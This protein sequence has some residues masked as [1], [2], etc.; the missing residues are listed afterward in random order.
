[1]PRI[2]ACGGRDGAYDRFC[3]AQRNAHA[4][5]FIILLVDSEEGIE[6]GV[7][8]WGFLRNRDGWNKPSGTGE[9]SAHLMVQCMEAWF[10][11]DHD[12]LA[13]FFGDGFNANSLPNR[14]DV[15]NI[16]KS[17]LYDALE[18]SHPGRAVRRE[19]GKGPHS[20][21]L[22][23][24]T[25]PTEGSRCLAPCKAACRYSALQVSL[26]STLTIGRKLHRVT[27][28][29]VWP[30]TE[31]RVPWVRWFARRGQWSGWARASERAE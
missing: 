30:A 9:D 20:F 14:S 3:T 7:G 23:A 15:E 5:E 21:D 28:P 24:T 19:Y 6:E 11:A 18:R 16:P 1:M 4:N 25:E 8:P 22:L 31:T 10:L 27:L 26:A 29:K 13:Q 2:I 17:D 12:T